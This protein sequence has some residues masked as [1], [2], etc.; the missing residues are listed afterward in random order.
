MIGRDRRDVTSLELVQVYGESVVKRRAE[1]EELDIEYEADF[2][3]TIFA[4]HS[5]NITSALNETLLSIGEDFK[6]NTTT[7]PDEY[8]LMSTEVPDAYF[9]AVSDMVEEQGDS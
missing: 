4:V 3:E 6:L 8:P 1:A 2:G 9:Q 7:F 5:D